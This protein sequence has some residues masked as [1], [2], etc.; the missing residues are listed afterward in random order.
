MAWPKESRQLRGYD[1]AWERTRRRVIERDKGLCQPCLRK[2]R[3][4]VGREV[5]HIVPKA[6]A[7]RRKWT[8][9]QT[10]ALTNLQTICHSCHNEKTARDNGKA[11]RPKIEFG[12]DGWPKE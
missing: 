2:G 7:A 6:E 3:V 11:Y 9:A 12:T 4:A 1:A 5:D 10:D 8:R